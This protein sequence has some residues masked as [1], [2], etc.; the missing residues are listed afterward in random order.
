MSQKKLV[1]ATIYQNVNQGE[2]FDLTNNKHLHHSKS[3]LIPNH[4]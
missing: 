1:L 4:R 2:V 3:K